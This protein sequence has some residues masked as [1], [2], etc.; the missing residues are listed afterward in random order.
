MRRLSV[1]VALALSLTLP[2][3]TFAAPLL[4]SST[5]EQGV[6][7]QANLAPEMSEEEKVEKAKELY[8]Q[9][10]GLAADQKWGE[11]MVLYEQAYY[12]VPG[13]HG[14]ALKVGIAAYNAQNCDKAF[15]YLTHF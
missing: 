7:V 10:E 6:A 14:F 11:A 5:F 2:A 9:A 3:T 8:G 1:P 4:G 13:K 15:E 12:L